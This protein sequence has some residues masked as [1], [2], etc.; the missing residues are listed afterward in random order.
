MK[1]VEYE[2]ADPVDILRPIKASACASIV[3]R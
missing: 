3:P 1:I 2:D